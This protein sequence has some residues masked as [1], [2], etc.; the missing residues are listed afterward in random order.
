VK[1]GSVE[2]KVPSLEK[3]VRELDTGKLSTI[4]GTGYLDKE[5]YS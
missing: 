1:Q 3:R 5:G 4:R 2:I